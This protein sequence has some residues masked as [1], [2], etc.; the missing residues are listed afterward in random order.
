MFSLSRMFC[1]LSFVTFIF[2]R[3]SEYGTMLEIRDIQYFDDG[4]SVVDTV[5]GR[6][7]KVLARGVKDGY[8]TATVEF[9]QDKPDEGEELEATK[10]QHAKIRAIAEKWFGKMEPQIKSGIL[11]HYGEGDCQY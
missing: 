1:L 2:S 5:G 4:R 11:G 9:L 7:F 6:R 10:E 3:F 8:N